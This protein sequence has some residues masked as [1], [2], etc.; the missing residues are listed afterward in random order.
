[1]GTKLRRYEKSSLLRCSAEK[2]F[3]FHL[4]SK[5][6]Q[7]ITPKEIKVELLEDSTDIYEGKILHLNITRSFFMQKWEVKIERLDEP[8]MI[9][10]NALRSPFGYFVHTHLFTP[11]DAKHCE[12][13]DRIHY[14]LPFGFIGDLFGALVHRELEK[15]FSYRHKK[16]RELLEEKIC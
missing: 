8:K 15:M 4:E 11:L 9:V 2:L 12:L 16:T 6:L 10:D 14:K 3:K 1:M 5:N 7:K 13:R